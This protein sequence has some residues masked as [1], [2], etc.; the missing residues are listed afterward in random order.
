MQIPSDCAMRG[1]LKAYA[2]A[3]MTRRGLLRCRS[4]FRRWGAGTSSWNA[5]LAACEE[6]GQFEL[7][8]EVYTALRAGELRRVVPRD[9]CNFL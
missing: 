9:A 2:T 4:R 1:L 3:G 5:F 7:A 8:V 6:A